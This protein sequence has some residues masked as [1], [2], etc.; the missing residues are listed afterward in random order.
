Y[1]ARSEDDR[2]LRLP[3]LGISEIV[4]ADSNG[5]GRPHTVQY[6]SPAGGT[7]QF[8]RTADQC[9]P[10]LGEK[11]NIQEYFPVRH[12]FAK[13]VFDI[14]ASLLALMLLAP[15]MLDIALLVKLVSPGPVLFRQSRVGSRGKIFTC[16]KFRTMHVNSDA[17]MHRTHMAS[18]MHDQKPM[19]KLEAVADPRIIPFGRFLRAVVPD[20]L[21]QLFN[22]LKGDMSLIGPRPC[23]VYEYKAFDHWHRTRTDALPGMT[24]LWQVKGKNR[25]TFA[26][27]MRLDI[28]Y[29]R[30]RFF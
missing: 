2:Q 6:C 1:P 8:G 27:M 26:Q 29:A 25:T 24:G 19:T 17:E 21:P 12:C 23:V 20:E 4:S 7:C 14:V 11:K 10:R 3:D 28:S 16:L 30:K 22:V 15:L 9:L 18:L 13:R 5:L